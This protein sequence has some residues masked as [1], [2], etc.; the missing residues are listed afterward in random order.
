MSTLACISDH[1]SLYHFGGD[2][3]ASLTPVCRTSSD[4][5]EFT[6]LCWNHTNQVVATTNSV[7]RKIKLWQASNANMLS[8][9]PFGVGEEFTQ[10]AIGVT[11]SNTSRFISA[12]VGKKC[13]VWDLKRRNLKASFQHSS[14]VSTVVYYQDSHIVAGDVSGSIKMWDIKSNS[15]LHEAAPPPLDTV[16]SAVRCVQIGSK[17][18]NNLVSGRSDGTIQVYDLSSFALL[19]HLRVHG[20]KPVT[21]LSLSPRNSKLLTS[22]GSDT[23]VCLVDISSGSGS[24]GDVNTPYTP[25][26]TIQLPDKKGIPTCVSCHENGF[27]VAI[28]STSGVVLMYD[29]RHSAIPVCEV[30][31]NGSGSNNTPGS[32]RSNAGTRRAGTINGISFQV[33]FSVIKKMADFFL[34]FFTSTLILSAYICC[35]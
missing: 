15:L 28:G 24:S 30:T 20:K 12:G 10:D 25:S 7:S 13:L 11:F 6:S 17:S 4:G 33:S 2:A 8:S 34:L 31:I 3:A 1:L 35:H 22:V 18:S 19:R 27:H 26:A 23:R 5:D 32:G 21:S 14:I 29:W 16:V 9:I